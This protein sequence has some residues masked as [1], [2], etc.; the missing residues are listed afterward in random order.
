M[1]GLANAQATEFA[2]P[3]ASLNSELEKTNAQCSGL[4]TKFD[5]A[6]SEIQN[7]KRNSFDP[8][9][10]TGRVISPP[11]TTKLATS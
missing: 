2:K 6:T 5:Q 7:A 8:G 1:A 4:Q 3:A 9:I 11:M 10:P